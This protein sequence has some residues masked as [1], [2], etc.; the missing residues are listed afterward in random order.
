M[1]DQNQPQTPS[2]DDSRPTPD[3]IQISPVSGAVVQPTSAPQAVPQPS[4]AAQARAV[5][6]AHQ[7]KL[8]GMF[9][10]I[11]STLAGPPR[12]QYT[13]SPDGQ[14]TA[15]PVP[16]SKTSLATSI[17][18]GALTG[19]FSGAAE[20]GPGSVGRSFQQGAAAGQGQLNA[21]NE[22]NQQDLQAARANYNAAQNAI[23]QKARITRQ[24]LENIQLS[25]ALAQQ[26]LE[27][28]RQVIS[29][30]DDLR[31]AIVD[32]NG[33]VNGHIDVNDDQLHQLMQKGEVSVDRHNALMV[34][35][36]PKIDANGEPMTDSD[37][38]P[39]FTHHWMVYDPDTQINWQPSTLTGAIKYGIAGV[40]NPKTGQP[41]D[42]ATTQ[43][44]AST[45][46]GVNQK[47][48]ALDNLQAELNSYYAANY[49]GKP[50]PDV[51]AEFRKNQAAFYRDLIDW[52]RVEAGAT[53]SDAVKALAKYNGANKTT[54]GTI[55]LPLFGGA[56]AIQKNAAERQGEEKA[57]TAQLE[58]QARLD[59]QN[60]PENVAAEARRVATK[61]GAE[62]TAKAAAENAAAAVANR[63]LQAPTDFTPNPNASD[64]T[65]AQL[66]VDLKSRGVTV[67]ENFDALY[68]IANHQAKLNTLP[69]NPRKGST[70]MSAQQ[71]LSY[72]HQFINPNYQESDYDAAAGFNKE[73]AS[74]KVGTAGGV[75]LNAGTASQHL[76]LLDEAAKALK[77]HDIQYL[78]KIGNALH[79]AIGDS[80]VTTFNAI[81][82][83]VNGEVGK[84]VAGGSPH[85][86]ELNELRKNLNSDQSPE[87]TA[88]TIRAYVGLMNGRI[89]E[90]DD[91]SMQYFKRHIHL[92]PQTQQV[93]SRYG[94]TVPGFVSVTVDGK[95]GS[96]PQNQVEAFKRKY[97]NATIGGQ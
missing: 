8:A 55:I 7:N 14:V 61:T 15:T 58:E 27:Y 19:L 17:I 76:A 6:E 31:N 95:S 89:N 52:N 59:T 86:A 94:G 85:E 12:L 74:S 34:G 88:K 56:D 24:N 46:A 32:N 91:R 65:A 21:V 28:Q 97:P 36:E 79:V 20:Q 23:V 30:H 66:K 44:N 90:I 41:Y 3:E 49:P 25:Q 53:E 9:R 63:A 78:N 26:S 54:A 18:A 60:A 42:L 73:L 84:V 81:S 96:I 68:S 70:A 67:P 64:M 11:A 50:I 38:K 57:R 10:S 92:S 33:V 62:A 22:A 80:P 37:G 1:T 48:N 69:P 16:R 77:N 83:Q 2:I 71:G 29:N 75:L 51:G 40:I 87:Q 93:F 72:I 43:S 39:I 4:P 45:V 47:I 35:V 13:T 82:E 5:D